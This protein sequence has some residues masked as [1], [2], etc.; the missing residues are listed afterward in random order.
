VLR[1]WNTFILTARSTWTRL[2]VADVRNPNHHGNI[3]QIS[4]NEILLV[5]WECH[6]LRFLWLP[7]S[8][9]LALLCGT[10]TWGIAVIYIITRSAFTRYSLIARCNDSE[11]TCLLLMGNSWEC[12]A[13]QL[14]TKKVMQRDVASD[15]FSQRNA[16]EVNF[17]Y[18]SGTV[19]SNR[20]GTSRWVTQRF[21]ACTELADSLSVID[22]LHSVHTLRCWGREIALCLCYTSRPHRCGEAAITLPTT[23]LTA[24]TYPYKQFC[25][26][27][28]SVPWEG[29][30]ILRGK[31]FLHY[32]R[33][34]RHRKMNIIFYVKCNVF[35]SKRWW[36]GICEALKIE[37]FFTFSCAVE[38]QLFLKFKFT[39]VYLTT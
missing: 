28:V 34:L 14:W 24:I 18:N 20:G 10:R 6:S 16:V 25:A 3:T 8:I 1:F 27:C 26:T 17:W 30:L 29:S 9:I 38:L 31:F 7:G 12:L 37:S 15:L 13:L 39:Y 32:R 36:N 4:Q 22:P 5:H 21:S 11:W 2:Y 23:R 19:T 33:H 35:P